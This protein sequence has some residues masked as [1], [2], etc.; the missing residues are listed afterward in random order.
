MMA[1]SRVYRSVYASLKTMAVSAI[2]LLIL[3]V[4]PI[5]GD[6]LSR[7]I[8]LGKT[9]ARQVEARW[10]LVQNPTVVARVRMI[11]ER[12]LPM[13][14]RPLPYDVR[15]IRESVP[16]AFCIPGGTVYVTTGLLDF[17]RSDA[18]LAAIL[19]HE[20]T[21][22]DE[23]HVMIQAKRSQRLSLASLAIIIATKGQ[24]AAGLLAGIAQIAV[25]NGYSME[26]ER[27]ADLGGLEKLQR[28]GY[29]PA[30]AL[31]VMEGLA[32]EGIKRPSVDPGIFRDHP[33]TAERVEYIRRA[34]LDRGWS[35]SRK[36]ALHLLVPSVQSASGDIRLCVDDEVVWAVS[37]DRSSQV[38]QHAYEAL[39]QW[40]ELELSP[41]DIQVVTPL[42]GATTLLIGGHPV[43]SEPVPSGAWSLNVFR[44]RLLLVLSRAKERNPMVDYF[45]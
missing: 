2:F 16:N 37:S 31:T 41:H 14:S 6:S 9:V 27:E 40:L 19:A 8:A 13:V 1:S 36:K 29:P 3:G 23:N 11:F 28:A 25:T 34:I 5:W 42:G 30:A 17:V 7:E 35:L 21:H 33:R 45:F 10:S 15:V 22:A 20:L 4:E 32:Y 43:A 44:E 38:F 12:L 26:L 24:G 18:E 39:V